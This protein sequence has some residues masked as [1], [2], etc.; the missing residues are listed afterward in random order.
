LKRALKLVESKQ[1]NFK[2]NALHIV[3]TIKVE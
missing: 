1:R 2:K 3:H